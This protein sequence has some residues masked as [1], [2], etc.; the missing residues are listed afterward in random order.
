MERSEVARAGQ[1]GA[2]G[3]SA[4]AGDSGS[5]PAACKVQGSVVQVTW[6]TVMGCEARVP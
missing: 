2:S 3:G 5:G 1:G 4:M 6:V